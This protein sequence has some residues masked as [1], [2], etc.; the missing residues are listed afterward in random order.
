MMAFFVW[1]G[2]ANWLIVEVSGLRKS[3]GLLLLFYG[4]SSLLRYWRSGT[5]LTVRQRRLFR[6]IH[7]NTSYVV[8]VF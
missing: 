5:K 7:S 1:Y 2:R 6:A 4:H 8:E 3:L